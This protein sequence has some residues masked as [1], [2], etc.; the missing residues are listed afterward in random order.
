MTTAVSPRSVSP[1]SDCKGRFYYGF[2]GWC[3]SGECCGWYMRWYRPRIEALEVVALGWIE[4]YRLATWRK[5]TGGAPVGAFYNA[6]C[7]CGV[8]A[9]SRPQSHRSRLTLTRVLKSKLLCTEYGDMA[10]TVA[11]ALCPVYDGHLTPPALSTE[12]VPLPRT[13]FRRVDPTPNTSGNA[14]GRSSPYG[15]GR[16]VCPPAR[17]KTSRAERKPTSPPEASTDPERP[18][19]RSS[20]SQ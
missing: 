4:A 10:F 8:P 3:S 5:R 19:R 1:T 7:C 14:G 15:T 12:P 20:A 11:C 6:C 13:A 2:A 17:E 9:R 18:S 16:G